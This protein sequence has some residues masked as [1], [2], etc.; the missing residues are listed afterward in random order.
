MLRVAG[1]KARNVMR[2][3]LSNR[4]RPFAEIN[5]KYRTPRIKMTR[6]VRIALLLVTGQASCIPRVLIA[7]S[8]EESEECQEECHA[9][10]RHAKVLP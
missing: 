5:Q 2:V 4:F 8:G 3:F 1:G 6:Q 7:L 10:R 9:D